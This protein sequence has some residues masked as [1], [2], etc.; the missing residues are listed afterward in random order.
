ML[1]M[2]SYMPSPRIQCLLLLEWDRFSQYWFE[3]SAGSL[4]VTLFSM[5]LFPLQSWCSAQIGLELLMD[6][7]LIPMC[8]IYW[9]APS[10]PAPHSCLINMFSFPNNFL[11]TFFCFILTYFPCFSIN[12]SVLL[13][14]LS[15]RFKASFLLTSTATRWAWRKESL[16][17]QWLVWILQWHPM[18]SQVR[19]TLE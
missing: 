10:C 4:L 1:Y 12:N 11:V 8:W 18:T 5:F 15:V 19:S 17:C 16:S 9:Q 14:C 6:L 7:F 3:E 2:L 13:K